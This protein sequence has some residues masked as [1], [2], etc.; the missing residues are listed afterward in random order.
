MVFPLSSTPLSG[1]RSISPLHR[2]EVVDGAVPHRLVNQS[3]SRRAE[4][5]QASSLGKQPFLAPPLH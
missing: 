3:P 1:S 5:P 2:L 4:L